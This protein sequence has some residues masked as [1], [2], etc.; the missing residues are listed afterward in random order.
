MI[1]ARVDVLVLRKRNLTK[2]TGLGIGRSP[3]TIN[4]NGRL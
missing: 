1:P 4:K 3:T 2:K